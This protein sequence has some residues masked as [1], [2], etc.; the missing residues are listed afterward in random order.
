[1]KLIPSQNE[2]KYITQ[3]SG[4]KEGRV[5]KEL[6]QEFSRRESQNVG[7]LFKRDDFLLNQRVRVQSGSVRGTSR[8][9]NVENQEPTQDRSQKDLHPE[10]DAA[11]YRS[12]HYKNSDPDE[13]FYSNNPYQTE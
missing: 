9:V 4:E 2:R 5:T 6:S 10:R 8:N 11:T 7:A 12:T 1:M 3:A 13:I